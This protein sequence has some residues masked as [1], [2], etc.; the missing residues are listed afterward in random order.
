[1]LPQNLR[2]ASLVGAALVLLSVVIATLLAAHM[3][4][5]ALVYP[6]PTIE[7]VNLTAATPVRVSDTIHLKVAA[8]A[9]RE[10]K[11]TWS[12]G[13]G[14]TASGL[15]VTHSYKTYGYYTVV[16]TASD[17]SGQKTTAS[18]V[19]TVLPQAPKAAFSV[20]HDRA[21]NYMIQVDATDSSGTGLHYYWDFG[22]GTSNSSGL[23]THLAHTY[24]NPGTYP[25]T[26]TV[27]DGAGQRN[28][29]TIQVTV[30]M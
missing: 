26:L 1:M 20:T 8:S 11:Y 25:V 12:L 14:A 10:L 28:M 7:L 16:V 24:V 22:D 17:P 23:Q 9:G 27:I 2:L 29:V 5:R 6:R 4:T 18:T 3:G 13:D 15:Q 30:H 19:L 21:Y